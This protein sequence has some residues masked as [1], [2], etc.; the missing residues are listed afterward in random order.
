MNTDINGCWIWINSFFEPI[1]E[2]QL[3]RK[4][5]LYD[6]VRRVDVEMPGIIGI[7][8]NTPNSN[9]YK[10]ILEEY[11]NQFRIIK[12]S[13]YRFNMTDMTITNDLDF[14]SVVMFDD[15]I[16]L[17][18]ITNPSYQKLNPKNIEIIRYLDTQFG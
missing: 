6:D 10:F 3:E 2:G 17:K 14:E 8:F 12:Q 5:F 18:G 13:E 16:T 1:N 4:D 11:E 7:Y 9:C 15:I